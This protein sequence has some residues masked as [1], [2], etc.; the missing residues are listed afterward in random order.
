MGG[1]VFVSIIVIGGALLGPKMIKKYQ[2]RQADSEKSQT[3]AI[4]DHQNSANSQNGNDSDGFAPI[5]PDKRNEAADDATAKSPEN[6]DNSNSKK[7]PVIKD[8]VNLDVQFIAQAP[9]SADPAYWAQHKE[10]CEEAASLMAHNYAAGIKTSLQKADRDIYALVAWQK[11][12]FGDEHDIYPPE[13]KKMI[14]GFWH[15]KDVLVI[16]K[17]TLRQIK[18]QI[19]QGYPVIVPTVAA[20][21]NNPRYYDRDYHMILAKGYTKD[22]VITHD[23]GT[24]WGADYVYSNKQFMRALDAAGGSVVVIRNWFMHIFGLFFS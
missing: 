6:S 22:K 3:L 10:S 1:G 5:K 18:E 2:I 21:L 4:F 15:H 12:H 7:K 24:T 16:N 13:V 11:D 14:Q 20:Y 23:N 8:R 9:I 19:S 17:A